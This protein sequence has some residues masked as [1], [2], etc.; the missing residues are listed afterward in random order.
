LYVD[1]GYLLAAA[2]TR[3]TGT[4]LRSGV[5]VD[6]PRLISALIEQAEVASDLP[7]LRVHWYDSARN[8]MLDGVLQHIALLPR[9]KVRLGRVGFSGEQK[10]VDLRIGLDM[11]A[12]A[13]NGAVDVIVLLS[14]DDDLT[15][16][17]EEAQGHGVEVVLL[18]VPGAENR[19]H[20][21]SRHLQQEADR[22]EVIDARTLDETVRRS[23]AAAAAVRDRAGDGPPESGAESGAEPVPTPALLAER[24]HRVAEVPAGRSELVYTTATGA[25]GGALVGFVHDADDVAATIDAVAGRVLDTWLASAGPEQREGLAAGRPTIPRDVDRALLLDLSDALHIEDLSDPI[26]IE[27][28]ARFWKKVDV[29]DNAV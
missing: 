7:L 29:A 16:A 9:V 14:G 22:L 1:A 25:G 20:A 24:K 27:L 23:G 13:R 3:L 28:R 18:A 5:D 15:E 6:H 12:H 26:R 8:G 21:V 4:S 17:V 11:A 2:A 10:G 19:P